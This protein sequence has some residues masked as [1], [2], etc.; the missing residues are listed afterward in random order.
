MLRF[1]CAKFLK[2]TFPFIPVKFL[3]DLM[4]KQAKMSFKDPKNINKLF[5]HLVKSADQVIN[6]GNMYDK[7]NFLRKCNPGDDYFNLKELRDQ[8]MGRRCSNGKL[9][10]FGV[11]NEGRLGV[12]LKEQRSAQS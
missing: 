2:S 5:Q 3:Q 6:Q 8:L 4:V 10:M 7:R 12:A 1:F 9:F 11:S